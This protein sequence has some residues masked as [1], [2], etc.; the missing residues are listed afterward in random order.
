MAIYTKKGDKGKTSLFS[1]GGEIRVDK[2]SAIVESLGSV[3]ELNSSVGE[4]K[5]LIEDSEKKK[6]LEDIQRCLL[7]IG[8]SV[9]GS[10]LD[11]PQS[12]I[13]ILERCIDD[14][15]GELPVLANFI[16]P[17]GTQLSAKIHF[18][19]SMARRAERRVVVVSRHTELDE[20]ILKY[21][22]R[23]SDFFFMLARKVNFDE[24]VKDEVWKGR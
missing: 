12:N 3:D 9:A 4:A 15:E 14:W 18:C 8:A 16:L 19:R 13:K 24:G 7:T 17:G 11:F 5:V 22:N 6:L 21:L 10:N 23:L 20:N 1:E 2:D